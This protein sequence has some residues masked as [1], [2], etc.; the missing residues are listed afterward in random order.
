MDVIQ[1]SKKQ[2]NEVLISMHEK[3]FLKDVGTPERQN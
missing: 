2:V 3:L 1:S